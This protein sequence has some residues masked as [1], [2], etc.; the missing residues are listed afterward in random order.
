M[1]EL[2][3][4]FQHIASD[5]HWD[6]FDCP[7]RGRCMYLVIR[8]IE[9]GLVRRIGT[10]GEKSKLQYMALYWVSHKFKQLKEIRQIHFEHSGGFILQDDQP[11]NPD[12]VFKHE[13]RLAMILSE[14][15]RAPGD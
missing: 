12:M 2:I 1:D 3:R 15:M 6:T 4:E 13:M 11:L 14:K 9:T 10:N 7:S 5:H 8:C